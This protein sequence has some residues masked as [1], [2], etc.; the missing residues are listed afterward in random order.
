MPPCASPPSSGRPSTR[1]TCCAAGPRPGCAGDPAGAAADFARVVDLAGDCGAPELT[2]AAR[3][4]L[5]RLALDRG[6]L[7]EARR[8]ALTALD[9]CPAGWYTADGVRMTILVT[10]GRA[11]AAAATRPAAGTGK[12][13]QWVPDRTPPGSWPP[14]RRGSPN[15]PPAEP[16]RE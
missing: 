6:A 7:A 16:G 4:G 5:A 11:A 15:L 8:L 10:L 13:P 2:A 12:C 14:P 3:L 9:E 1:P